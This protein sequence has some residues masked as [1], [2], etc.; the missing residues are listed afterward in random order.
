MQKWNTKTSFPLIKP[1][2]SKSFRRNSVEMFALNEFHFLRRCSGN[3][4]N[5]KLLSIR[6]SKPPANHPLCLYLC[7]DSHENVQISTLDKH[8]TDIFFL[9]RRIRKK[10][11]FFKRFYSLA[12]HRLIIW[13]FFDQK[14]F[15]LA[16]CAK[17]CKMAKKNKISHETPNKIYFQVKVSFYKDWKANRIKWNALNGKTGKF[18]YER[19]FNF[20]NWCNFVI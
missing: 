3:A 9:H 17:T 8:F 15:Q 7:W 14:L 13:F 20:R 2:E 10:T 4:W 19:K 1:N 16:S 11:I 18:I 6:I 12:F 5:S